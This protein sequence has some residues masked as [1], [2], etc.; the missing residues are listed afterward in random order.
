MKKPLA[1]KPLLRKPVKKPDPV[2]EKPTETTKDEEDDLPVAPKKSYNMDFLDQLDDPN[3]NPFETKTGV[4]NQFEA[5]E[6]VQESTESTD[7]NSVP[8]ANSTGSNKSSE[9]PSIEPASIESETQVNTSSDSAKPAVKP[10]NPLIKRNIKA[11]RPA[12]TKKPIEPVEDAE[13]TE[14]EDNTPLPPPK[15]YNMDFLDKLDN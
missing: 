1:R 9:N 15:S 2:E 10:K 3:F 12:P 7:T 6:F 5:S 14:N 4:K 11:K 13:N 8:E